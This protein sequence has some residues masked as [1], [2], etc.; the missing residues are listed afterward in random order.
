MKLFFFFSLLIVAHSISVY[1]YLGDES[2]ERFLEELEEEIT[3]GFLQTLYERS[4]EF[5]APRE[6]WMISK[7]S[8][9]DVDLSTH[10]CANKCNYQDIRQA[11]C[12]DK[13]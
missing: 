7:P 11:C 9:S 2:E 3:R 12:P 13:M 4:R 1:Q 10:C 6:H 8:G 5:F